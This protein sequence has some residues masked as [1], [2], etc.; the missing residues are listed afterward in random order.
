MRADSPTRPTGARS[1]RA[2]REKGPAEKAARGEISIACVMRASELDQLEEAMRR[3]GFHQA[4]RLSMFAGILALL[5]V[6]GADPHLAAAPAAQARHGLTG[7]YY[8]SNVEL[9]S[10]PNISTPAPSSVFFAQVYFDDNDFQLPKPFSD[11]A[12]TRIDPQIA[13]GKGKGFPPQGGKQFAWWASDY[14]AP[15][16]WP[17]PNQHPW[18]NTAAVI[19]KGYIHL[20]KAGTYYLA[21]VSNGPSAVYLNQARVALNG[22]FGGILNIDA[23]AYTEDDVHDLIYV[24]GAPARPD[25]AYRPRPGDTYVVPVTIDAPRD[26][27]IEV[28]Y[29][30]W[31]NR[32]RGID[33]FWVTPDAPRDANGRPIAQI[34]PGDALYVDPPGAIE[35]PAVHGANSTISAD[36]LYFPAA[37]TD[38]FVTLTIRLEDENGKPIAGKRVFVS[39]VV[40]YGNADTIIQ[41]DKPTDENG[42]TT[43]KV[44][45][46][47]GYKV[48]HDSTFF[49]TDVTD[50]VDVAQVGH[51]TFQNVTNSFLPDAFSPYYD[52]NILSVAPLPMIVGKPL[53]VKVRLLDNTQFPAELTVTFKATDWNIGATTW[54]EI[55][56]VENITLKPGESKEISVTWTPHEAQSHQCFRVEISGHYT[57]LNNTRANFLMAALLPVTNWG[58]AFSPPASS[59]TLLGSLQRNIG[60]VVSCTPQGMA[61]Y[62]LLG[63]GIADFC[64][65]TR[66]PSGASRK[67][68]KPLPPLH[69][70]SPTAG[71]EKPTPRPQVTPSVGANPSNAGKT[72]KDMANDTRAQTLKRCEN[73]RHLAAVY[74]SIG[75]KADAKY[76][77]D[78]YE[79][80]I[81]EYASWQGIAQDPQDNTYQQLAVA[82]SDSPVGYIDAARVSLE[83]YQAAQDNGDLEWMA[84]HITAM[85]LY[86]KRIAK[87]E[88]L[89]ADD[90]EKQ[91]AQLPPDD[92]NVTAKAQAD[93]DNLF[94]RLRT[95]GAAQDDLK[96]LELSGMTEDQA[97]A[98]YDDLLALSAPLQLK[99]SHATLLDSAALRRA[100]ADAADQVAALSPSGGV[101]GSMFAQTYILGNPHDKPE[102]VDLFIRPISIPPNWKLAIVN[103]QENANGASATPTANPTQPVVKEIEPGK[104]YAVTLPAKGQI[105]VASVLIPVGEV[106]AN[107]TARWAVE[108]KIGDELIGGMVHEMNVP[109][110]IPDLQLPPVGSAPQQTTNPQPSAAQNN[111]PLYA[112]AALIALAIVLIAVLVMGRRRRA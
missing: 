27:P 48:G 56:K 19:W 93:F 57:A 22:N 9:H 69:L 16:G 109:Y 17:N 38:K 95:S 78:Q 105:Q 66:A 68:P 18:D 34:V 90:E 55:G 12:T 73:A 35:K 26:V 25:I 52:D 46:G 20:P 59:D 86:F 44:N 107:T 94:A 64:Y 65:G 110:I 43:A 23:F 71:K 1:N 87:A 67:P 101:E 30:M 45:T 14:P 104:H 89:A 98:Y 99:G 108:G 3:R 36:F 83:R 97:D 24:P 7:Y 40:S 11:A 4:A 29:Q 111:L 53:T 2:S 112:V 28:D 5:L 84:R 76:W 63:G 33:L 8:V 32:L 79:S 106:G 13:F 102:M 50:L 51:V 42:I 96:Q 82:S 49:A 6:Y 100:I 70:P 75:D 85:E 81:A 10:E 91:A 80:C 54:P 31:T 103:V 37:Y 39:G 47:A 41:P 58:N 92:A 21:T 77:H 60:P 62:T 88:R 61:L 15:Q 72:P 74:D